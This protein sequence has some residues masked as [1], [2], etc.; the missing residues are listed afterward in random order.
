[1]YPHIIIS[2]L[3][4]NYF[5]SLSFQPFSKIPRR[6]NQSIPFK[7]LIIMKSNEIST[8]EEDDPQEMII[9]FMMQVFI[10]FLFFFFLFLSFLWFLRKSPS[11]CV[12]KVLL[13]MQLDNAEMNKK[14]WKMAGMHILEYLI[15]ND[16]VE[17]LI[18]EKVW[19]FWN[20]Y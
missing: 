3:K 20:R 5:S 19:L 7:K 15:I 17:Y 13:K 18:V 14:G 11:L 4:F 12:N 9:L 2:G 10:L 6:I 16:H 8:R 1:M